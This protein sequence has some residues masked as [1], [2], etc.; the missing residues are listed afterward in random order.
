MAV[1]RPSTIQRQVISWILS[2]ITL[3]G[4]LSRVISTI[5]SSATVPG[6]ETAGNTGVASRMMCWVGLTLKPSGARQRLTPDPDAHCY[7]YA[8]MHGYCLQFSHE[9]RDR[10]HVDDIYT[11]F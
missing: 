11:D 6:A 2:R 9:W 1:A 10:T 3:D 8:R 7:P 4:I 5:A